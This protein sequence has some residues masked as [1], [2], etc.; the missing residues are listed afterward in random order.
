MEGKK[1]GMTR[2]SDSSLTITNF[3]SASFELTA[4]LLKWATEDRGASGGHDEASD[5]DDEVDPVT[6]TEECTASKD[7]RANEVGGRVR[8]GEV[9]RVRLP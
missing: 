5:K 4:P 9:L 3:F 2:C 1:R 7:R 6:H 8:H